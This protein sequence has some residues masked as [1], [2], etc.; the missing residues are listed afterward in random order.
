MSPAALQPETPKA[1]PVARGAVGKVHGGDWEAAVGAGGVLEYV[2]D[3]LVFPAACEACAANP[4]AACAWLAHLPYGS[5]FAL[6]FGTRLL[7]AAAQ[8]RGS[9]LRTLKL[10]YALLRAKVARW[11]ESRRK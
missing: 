9:T 5:G 4:E 8:D 3:N 6:G 11:I 2:F 7:A 1:E 10:A